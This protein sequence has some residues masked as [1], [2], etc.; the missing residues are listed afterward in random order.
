MVCQPLFLNFFHFFEFFDLLCIKLLFGG[1]YVAIRYRVLLLGI[2]IFL[3]YAA[4]HTL[5]LFPFPK[6]DMQ[7]ENSEAFSGVLRLWISEKNSA[8]PSGL[9][10]WLSRESAQFE[11]KHDGVYVQITPV[12]EKT[13]ASFS[14]AAELPPDMIVFSPGM[15]ESNEGLVKTDV[16]NLL[17]TEF[18]NYE[19]HLCTPI[20]IGASFWAIRNENAREPLSGKTLLFEKGNSLR[21]LYALKK[22]FS[23]SAP[24]SAQ[25]GIDLGLPISIDKNDES[26]IEETHSISPGSGSLILENAKSAFI[27]G[28]GDAILMTQKDLPY[29]INA[30]GSPEFEIAMTGD[31]YTDCLSL[32]S[33]TDAKDG[34]AKEMC[35]SFLKHLLS[36]DAQKRLESAKAFSVT[37]EVIYSGKSH[38]QEIEMML[39]EAKLI[40]A[41][42]FSYTEDP[43]E[44]LLSVISGSMRISD[45]LPV[46]P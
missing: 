41:P 4:I 13:L 2:V 40:P 10:A 38:Y 22:D 46:Q 16:S 24:H 1:D 11:K 26:I 30:S 33:V 6:D 20:A 39:S 34:E 45:A 17:R 28:E 32:F 27:K 18:Q 44:A 12:S 35:A 14:Y 15:L 42:A 9:S 7:K 43:E 3:V 29:L 25:Y 37:G 31:L 19:S 5:N 21:A 23:P 8:S 36:E